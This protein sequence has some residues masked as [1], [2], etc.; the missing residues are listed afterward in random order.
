MPL[1]QGGSKMIADLISRAVALGI[2][3]GEV[4]S[5][6]LPVDGEASPNCLVPLK[7]FLRRWR[8]TP[9]VVEFNRM[10][11]KLSDEHAYVAVLHADGCAVF[12]F[13][14]AEVAQW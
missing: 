9:G 8:G 13:T 4:F 10:T 2:Q 1:D 6:N 3:P 14:T 5:C 7:K 11:R 12:G